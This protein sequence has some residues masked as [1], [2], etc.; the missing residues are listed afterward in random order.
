M[1]NDKK[2]TFREVITKLTVISS[3]FWIYDI[4]LRRYR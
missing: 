3:E 1:Y 2:Y 4:R